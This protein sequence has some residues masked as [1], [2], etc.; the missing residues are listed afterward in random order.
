M[1]VY[2]CMCVYV[3]VQEEYALMELE[4]PWMSTTVLREG[5]VR[6]D[7]SKVPFLS[8]LLPH[9][10]HTSPGP[11]FSFLRSLLSLFNSHVCP[12]SRRFSLYVKTRALRRYPPRSRRKSSTWAR[13]AAPGAANAAA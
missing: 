12:S 3:C 2:V 13:R 8:L 9:L 1:R 7:A 6:I 4:M 11:L 10:S 5:D